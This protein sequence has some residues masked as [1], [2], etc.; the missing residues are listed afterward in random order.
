MIAIE[1]KKIINDCLESHE[2]RPS[3]D[4]ICNLVFNG[5]GDDFTNLEVYKYPFR[6]L[7]FDEIFHG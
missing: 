5:N 1:W 3:M 4:T 7:S 6:Q 2:Y